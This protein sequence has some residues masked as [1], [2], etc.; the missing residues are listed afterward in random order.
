[1]TGKIG[2]QLADLKATGGVFGLYGTG[3]IAECLLLHSFS[4]YGPCIAELIF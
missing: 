4:E 1:M 2:D 3:V